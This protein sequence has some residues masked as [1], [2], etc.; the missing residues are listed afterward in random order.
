MNIT[1]KVRL[2]LLKNAGTCYG[3][4]SKDYEGSI[5]VGKTNGYG[6][7]CGLLKIA[8]LPELGISDK[9]VHAELDLFATAC[10]PELQV[11]L[12]RVTTDWQQN[13]VC[14]NSGVGFD[15]S[16]VDYQTVQIM[17]R[18]DEGKDRWQRFEITDLV[19]GWYSGEIPNYGVFLRSDKENSSSQARVWFLS[20]AYTTSDIVRPI[21]RL[22]YRNMSGFEDYWSYTDLSAGQNGSASVNNYNGN[23]VYAQP[24]TTDCGGNLMPVNISLVYNSNVT[25]CGYSYMGN[26]FLTN[27]HVYVCYDAGTA[28]QGYRI[29][30]T[31]CRRDKT[32]V[33]L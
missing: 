21:L 18:Y 26:G 27:Y 9:V 16:V 8:N 13:T 2:F 20:S 24:V 33:L 17:E 28:P 10:Y 31:R 23:L 5:Y 1:C 11:N 25:N 3:R 22:S 29:F 30:L 19:R 4:G 6:K 14:W 12:H 15:S 32:L 7:T